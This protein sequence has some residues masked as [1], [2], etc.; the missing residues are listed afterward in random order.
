MSWIQKL[1]F[2]GTLATL[3]GLA[4][5]TLEAIGQEYEPSEDT[6]EATFEHT[7][8]DGPTAFGVHVRNLYFKAI[9][10]DSE[11]LAQVLELLEGKLAEEPDHPEALVYH[12][13]LQLA[14]SGNAFQKGDMEQGRSLWTEGLHEMDRA[15]EVAPDR[16]D[17]RIPRGATLL[18]VSREVP[19]DRAPDLLRRSVE[20]YGTAYEL[21]KDE[22]MMLSTHSRGE[23]LLGLAD[24]Y[25]R[26]GETEKA[27]DL[28]RQAV[29]T[30]PGTDYAQEAQAHLEADSIRPVRLCLGCHHTEDEESVASR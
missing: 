22:L 10:G 19:P 18:F 9:R 5:L 12:G 30:L 16:L 3:F 29:E 13:S 28:F 25:Q 17:I 4:A 6:T 20:D 23:L 21:Q 2:L 11:A 27:R 7:S 14:L 1:I 15:V 24:G 26:L 8:E